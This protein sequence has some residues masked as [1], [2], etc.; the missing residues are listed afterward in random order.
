MEGCTKV[1]GLITIW[2]AWVSILG[3]MDV[4]TWENIW[5]TRSTDT[6]YINGQMVDSILDNGSVVNRMVWAFIK[7]KILTSNSVS[8]RM[9]NV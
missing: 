5:M 9:V 3:L 2:M 6:E 4:A 1:N 8:G 7:P